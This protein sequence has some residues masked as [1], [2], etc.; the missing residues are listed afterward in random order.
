MDILVLE[1]V[2][3]MFFSGVICEKLPCSTEL[4]PYPCSCTQ[5]KGKQNKTAETGEDCVKKGFR[6]GNERS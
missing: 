5:L 4:S 1:N 6:V 2:G 3:A